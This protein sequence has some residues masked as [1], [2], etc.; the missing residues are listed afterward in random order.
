L[1]PSAE[2]QQMYDEACQELTD[3]FGL[4]LSP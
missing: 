1:K 3:E 4:D 2:W